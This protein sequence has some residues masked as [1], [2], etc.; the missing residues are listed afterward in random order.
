MRYFTLGGQVIST[1]EEAEKWLA[2]GAVEITKED[3]DAI[4][5]IVEVAPRKD[6][7]EIL[8]V[9]AGSKDA[10]EML[11]LLKKEIVYG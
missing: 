5:G 1:E 8:K 10:E 3:K 9:L 6:A 7:M 2:K 11:S 4:L